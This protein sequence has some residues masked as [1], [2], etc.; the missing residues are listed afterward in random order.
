MKAIFD[1]PAIP[2][3]IVSGLVFAG[4]VAV[5]ILAARRFIHDRMHGEG[6]ANGVVEITLTVFSTFYGILLGL[7]VV[8]AYENVNSVND[9]V[10]QEADAISS[11]Y[12]DFQ[13]FPEPARGELEK[14]L[15]DYTHEVVDN[16]FVTQA[17]GV[18]PTGETRFIREIFRT[19]NSF[20]PKAANEEALQ[21]ETMSQLNDLQDAR[22]ARL[23]NYDIS[24]PATL[25]WIV[26][27]GA[28]I[29]LL[30]I[31]VL[32]FPLKLHVIFG[33]LLAFFIGATIFVIASMDNPFSG[34]DHVAPEAI[35][36]LIRLEKG[37]V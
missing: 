15:W 26:G 37:Q 21:S 13:S 4:I 20:E 31:C 19:L 16:S 24:I 34:S 25:W 6:P 29:N 35:R 11:L 1:Y 17:H 36:E 30:L 33:G 18:R 8:G 14:S 2:M 10:A 9:L 23:N 12:W 28:A 22:H 27:L 32:D 5:G 7:L 3:S